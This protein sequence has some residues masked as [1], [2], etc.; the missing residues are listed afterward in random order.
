[1]CIKQKVDEETGE[2]L[3]ASNKCKEQADSVFNIGAKPYNLLASFCGLLMLGALLL[4]LYSRSL[5]M[6]YRRTLEVYQAFMAQFKETPRSKIIKKYLVDDPIQETS[7]ENNP[8]TVRH[9]STFKGTNNEHQMMMMMMKGTYPRALGS[10]VSL[11]ESTLERGAS[12][13]RD[14]Q[15][16]GKL[17]EEHEVAAEH[18]SVKNTII[19]KITL[20]PP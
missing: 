10:E 15:G 5:I 14:T 12:I 4:G 16:R 7:E 17:L 1:M 11:R 19:K 6:N 8:T 20:Y 18:M 2:I 9:L 13:R 3:S